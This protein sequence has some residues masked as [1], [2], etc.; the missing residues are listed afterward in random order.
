MWCNLHMYSSYCEYKIA[1]TIF[2]MKN[3][4]KKKAFIIKTLTKYFLERVNI[5][6]FSPF[7]VEEELKIQYVK[8]LIIF[9]NAPSSSSL[10]NVRQNAF[11][12]LLYYFY[13][14]IFLNVLRSTAYHLID[15]AF[16][17]LKKLLIPCCLFSEQMFL[18]FYLQKYTKCF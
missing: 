12:E 9:K 5:F 15:D 16:T 1:L 4:E 3:F 6:M 13:F 7:S 14:S 18:N 2:Y 10:S 11:I 8:K 17:G